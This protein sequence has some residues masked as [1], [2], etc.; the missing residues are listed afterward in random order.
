M[1]EEE[2][3]EEAL[4]WKVAWTVKSGAVMMG[5]AEGLEQVRGLRQLGVLPEALT[6]AFALLAAALCSLCSA[7]T[8][9]RAALYSAATLAWAALCSAATLARVALCSL[10]S[11]ATLA[12]SSLSCRS[13]SYSSPVTTRASAVIERYVVLRA[14]TRVRTSVRSG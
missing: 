12:R 1:E 9:A 10:C 2:E 4:A 13:L 8:L 6:G 5:G 14:W 7:A 11:A 3:E